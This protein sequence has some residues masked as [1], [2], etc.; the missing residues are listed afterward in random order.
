MK[1]GAIAAAIGGLVGLALI[2]GL[3]AFCRIW[4]KKHASKR[5]LK[6]EVGFNLQPDVTRPTIPGFSA[7]GTPFQPSD[8]LHL[9]P[10]YHPNAINTN[11]QAGHPMSMGGAPVS[12]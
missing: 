12:R 7:P 2:G 4:K 10:F 3:V 6:P 8:A 1:I 9:T 5:A 11:P